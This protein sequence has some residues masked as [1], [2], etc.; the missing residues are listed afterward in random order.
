MIPAARGR[1]ARRRSLRR[2][3]GNRD[4][5]IRASRLP[6]SGRSGSLATPDSVGG[7]RCTSPSRASSTAAAR[8]TRWCRTS[9]WTLSIV[10]TG[11]WQR[12]HSTPACTWRLCRNFTC[13]GT[14]W[15]CTHG[16]GFCSSQN[17]LSVWTPSMS[18]PNC[19]WQPMHSSTDGTPAGGETGPCPVW[20]YMQS[21]LY[22]PAWS[23]WLNGIGW[24]G[25]GCVGIRR[26]G[27]GVV[28]LLAG[29]RA[30]RRG[31]GRLR[32]DR[33]RSRTDRRPDPRPGRWRMPLRRPAS[34][35]GSGSRS[36]APHAQPNFVPVSRI[37]VI[38]RRRTSE[39]S[40]RPRTDERTRTMSERLRH[41][42][43]PDRGQRP[44]SAIRRAAST[45]DNGVDRVRRALVAA[46]RIATRSP[47]RVASSYQTLVG[48]A[49]GWRRA[50]R[51]P[52]RMRA[53]PPA[54]SCPTHRPID[55]NRDSAGSCARPAAPHPRRRR[56]AGMGEAWI[57]DAVRTPRGKGKK[58]TGAL[59]GIHPQELLA[60]ALN[61][62]RS[63][64]AFDPRDVE[65]VVAGCVS[66]SASRAPASRAT[67]CS[68]RAGRS[69]DRTGVTLNR[70]C[71]SGQ[72]AVNFAAM[73]VMAR[74]AGS[75]DRRRRRVD[76][77]R[78]DGLR[79]RRD[80]RPQPA[81]AS[82][83]TRWCRRASRPI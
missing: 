55:G 2:A 19:A 74:P 37:P 59:S 50:G 70:F 66:R 35:D 44:F 81:P 54:S 5:G 16:I 82:S 58:D 75:R 33:L 71:G 42:P 12:W 22:S 28:G 48:D 76:V 45:V 4:D 79:R 36:C 61:A 24:R 52:A 18:P 32:G 68:P 41:V 49:R 51:R 34:T 21:I 38:R 67:R 10:S 64:S 60:Q 11:P 26:G 31:G 65:D 72:Q 3:S 56:I 13:S 1:G 78:A 83:C 80:R 46:S 6:S 8:A 63:A 30:G 17:F 69:E 14:R 9:R 27:L 20:Q 29:L 25:P 57:I 23:A 39:E 15:I 73:G 62:L 40:L 7:S 53:P 47:H 43:S 77:A